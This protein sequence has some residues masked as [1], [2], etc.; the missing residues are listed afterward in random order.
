MNDDQI[1]QYITL[2]LDE[3]T[4][5]IDTSTLEKLMESRQKALLSK[6]PTS[7]MRLSS[8]TGAMDMEVHHSSFLF[9]WASALLFVSACTIGGIHYWQ[10]Q[11]DQ[12]EEIGQ[13]DA[14]LLASDIAP[15]DLSSKEFGSWLSENP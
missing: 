10:Q 9:K 1:I 6:L 11:T 2:Q 3:A 12:D 8:G 7:V 14:N 5:T 4:K 15:Q 13:L